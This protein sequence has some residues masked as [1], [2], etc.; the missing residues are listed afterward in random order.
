MGHYHLALTE[1]FEPKLNLSREIGHRPLE[2]EGLVK[3]GE[4]Y[5]IY[6]GDFEI[7]LDYIEQARQIWKGTSHERFPYL[8]TVQIRIMQGKFEEAAHVLASAQQTPSYDFDNGFLAGTYLAT[9]KLYNT[10]DNADDYHHVLEN[11]N[12]VYQIIA[13]NPFIT[14][15]FEM[16]AAY[17]AAHAH[18]KLAQIYAGQEGESWHLNEG[19]S[20]AQR[21]LAIYSR[22]G[23]TQIIECVSEAILYRY[24]QALVAHNRTIEAIDYLEQAYKEMT[25]KASLIPADSPFRDSYLTAI[26][27]HRAITADYMA[28]QTALPTPGPKP[29]DPPPAK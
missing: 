1:Y 3:C 29:D 10:F 19:L 14:Q 6:L 25:R 12:K 24:S 5:G 23:F 21:A 13:E 26:P 20:A 15:Q 4:I 27:L 22:F 2:A 8:R 28:W 7:G 18:L 9:C 11:S 16:A 17:E